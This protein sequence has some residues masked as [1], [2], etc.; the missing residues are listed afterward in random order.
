[1]GR[2]TRFCWNR[3]TDHENLTH[4]TTSSKAERSEVLSQD[5][6]SVFSTVRGW[7]ALVLRKGLQDRLAASSHCLQW[8]HVL[9]DLER[10][11]QFTIRSGA[12]HL[13]VPKKPSIPDF[14]PENA[15]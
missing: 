12:T 9:R 14:P 5:G 8:A 11:R 6:R 15:I 13:S 10:L 7:W 2:W 3:H 4:P 1:M